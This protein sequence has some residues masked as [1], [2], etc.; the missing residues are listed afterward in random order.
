MLISMAFSGHQY[1]LTRDFSLLLLARHPT[2]LLYFDNTHFQVFS[3][4]NGA[5]ILLAMKYS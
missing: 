4:K 3:L 5:I 1:N 2:C